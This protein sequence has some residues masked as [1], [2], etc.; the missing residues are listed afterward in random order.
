MVKY[1]QH[2]IYHVSHFQGYSSVPP[3]TFLWYECE[4][5]PN[6]LMC[7]SVPVGSIVYKSCATFPDRVSLEEARHQEVTLDNYSHASYSGL[8]P[9]QPIS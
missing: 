8:F 7:Y 3:R 5:F 4:M 2:K 1:T 6:G 9:T